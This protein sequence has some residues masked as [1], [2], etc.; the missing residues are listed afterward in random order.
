MVELFSVAA[1]QKLGK[2]K[3][4]FKTVAIAI[5]SAALVVCIILIVFTNRSNATAMK[6]AVCLIAITAGWA[7]I[8]LTGGYILPLRRRG[9]FEKKVLASATTKI[10]GR[11]EVA[12]ADTTVADGVSCRQVTV[13]CGDKIYYAY[14]DNYFGEPPFKDGATYTFRLADNIIAAY[15]EGV[16]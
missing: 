11:A 16:L 3:N 7:C 12:A 14:W 5:G 1:A 4:K 8:A 15:G 2:T 10:C 9:L 6:T 13:N